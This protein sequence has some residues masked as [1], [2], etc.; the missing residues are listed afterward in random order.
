MRRSRTLCARPGWSTRAPER[1]VGPSVRPCAQVEDV[2]DEDEEEEE[3]DDDDDFDED[4]DED[5][6]PKR[7]RAKPRGKA[8]T[9]GDPRGVG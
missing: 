8:V 4:D 2:T 7:S 1:G 6:K 5:E 3:E 9:T